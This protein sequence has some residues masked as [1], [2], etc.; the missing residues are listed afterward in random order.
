[1]GGKPAL[2]KWIRVPGGRIHLREDLLYGRG[3]VQ[4]TDKRPGREHV[5][6]DHCTWTDASRA[7]FSCSANAH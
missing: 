3:E 7:G 4:S 5:Q 1:M 2:D 6:L